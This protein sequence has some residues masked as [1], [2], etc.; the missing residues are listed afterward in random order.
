MQML[1]E[2]KLLEKVQSVLVKDDGE[3]RHIPEPL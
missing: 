3:W 2:A 1:S